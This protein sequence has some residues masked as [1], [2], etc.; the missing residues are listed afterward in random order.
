MKFNKLPQLAVINGFS[1]YPVIKTK[2]NKFKLTL[3]TLLICFVLIVSTFS[4]VFV[5][6]KYDQYVQR[7]Q[8]F[9]TAKTA[10]MSGEDSILIDATAQIIVNDSKFKMPKEVAKQ[11][12]IWI[13]ESA[14]KNKVD[15]ILVL[16]VMSVES[17]FDYK[18]MSGT[19]AVGL[20]Q[21]I[22]SWHQEKTTKAGLFDPKINIDVGTQI[23]KEYSKRSSTDVETLL[24]Y[25][26]TL[27]EAPVYATK[28]LMKHKKYENEIF[29]S[30]TGDV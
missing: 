23:I 1:Q 17:Q 6:S 20:M 11:Y 5:S 19:G 30:I 21:V 4:Y 3:K 27:G 26:G 2:T 9:D 25:N 28:V 22:H 13:F 18:A 29:K 8:L 10:A 16:S 24:R 7:T 14:A 12:A 15:P